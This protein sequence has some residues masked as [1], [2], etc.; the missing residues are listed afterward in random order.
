MTV[1]AGSPRRIPKT[2]RE[3]GPGVYSVGLC[4]S[5]CRRPGKAPERIGAFEAREGNVSRAEYRHAF[6]DPE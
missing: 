3:V 4:P 2:I 5:T 6:R 1:S